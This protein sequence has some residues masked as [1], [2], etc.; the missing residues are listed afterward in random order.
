MLCYSSVSIMRPCMPSYSLFQM[1]MCIPSICISKCMIK[2][3]RR[4]AGGVDGERV[5]VKD[6]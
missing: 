5:A 3:F 1:V 6:A 4:G 2:I